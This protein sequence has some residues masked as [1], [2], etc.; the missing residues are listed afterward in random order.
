MIG[1]RDHY[2]QQPKIIHPICARHFEYQEL[3]ENVSMLAKARVLVVKVFR[4]VLALVVN[5][6]L[7]TRRFGAPRPAGNGSKPE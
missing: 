7:S 5:E 3:L 1:A 4:N 6:G 2:C